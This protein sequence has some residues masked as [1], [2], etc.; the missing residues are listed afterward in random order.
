MK[1][2]YRELNDKI[3][4]VHMM[5]RMHGSDIKNTKL[6]EHLIDFGKEVNRVNAIKQELVDKINLKHAAVD[7]NGLLRKDEKGSYQYTKG[8]EAL[9]LKDFRNLDSQEIEIKP[10][11]CTEGII[12][13]KIGNVFK[14]ELKGIV[15]P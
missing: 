14:D 5:G 3:A 12:N 4:A 9:R 1:L 6:N 10:S 8:A 15:F 11:I 7:E 13:S 2:T